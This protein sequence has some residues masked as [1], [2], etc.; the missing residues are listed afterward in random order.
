MVEGSEEAQE[1]KD[2]GGDKK[3]YTVS[4]PFLDWWCVVALK[5]A[6]SYNVSSSLTHGE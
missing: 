3:D 1:E 5:C 2:F 6:F 4:E